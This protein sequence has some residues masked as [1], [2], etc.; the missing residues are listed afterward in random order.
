MAA[1]D[2]GR[3]AQVVVAA[4]AVG[5]SVMS[6]KNGF[7]LDDV[8]II[9]INESMHSLSNVW[10]L[11]SSSYWPPDF[12]HALYRP[13]TSAV[14]AMQWAVGGGS[15]LPFHLVNILL[16]VAVSLYVLKVGRQLLEPR[17]AFAA[18]AIFAVHPLHVEAVANVVGQAELWAA[19]FL[20][21]GLSSFLAS[22]RNDRLSSSRVAGIVAL[23][24]AALGFKEHSIVFPAIVMAAELILPSTLSARE[25][26]F[27]LAPL[28]AAMALA[29]GLFLV[30]R[31]SVLGAFAGGSTATVFA[32][33]DYSARLFTM[34]AVMPEWLRLFVWPAQLSA[35][36]SPP[37]IET[38]TAFRM[39]MVPAILGIVGMV[40]IAIRTRRER[41]AFTFVLAFAGIALLIPSNLVIT[42]GFVLAERALFLATVG[43][44]LAAGY[45]I[46]RTLHS[47]R[48]VPW[49]RLVTAVA[50]LLVAAGLLR[51]AT[52]STVWR[53]NG[54]LFRQTVLDAPTSYRAHLSFGELLTNEG[55]TEEGLAELAMAVNL[56]RKQDYFVRWFA[57]DRFHAAG[58]LRVALGYYME[59][60]ALKP[61]DAKVRFGAAMAHAALEENVQARRLAAEGMK[62][63][64]EDARFARLV[65]VIDSVAAL[66]PGE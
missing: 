33:Q 29:A 9:A 50:C 13:L 52:R 48:P 36:Y 53:D 30:V 60:L 59:A 21:V 16:Y 42:T 44:A 43:L 45:L 34:L 23:Y 20:L 5:S 6:L 24:L 55:K 49:R 41:P 62:R 66:K 1:S 58:K 4:L 56:S 22:S 11:V 18:A 64:P 25:R 47:V 32:G 12:G 7:A 46:D 39:S 37:R 57:A 51:S 38:V 15:P 3:E 65:H 10:H 2:R 28:L 17:G 27:R 31:T 14:F 35:D 63:N 40:V 8:P 26:V 19:L 61:S 54:T